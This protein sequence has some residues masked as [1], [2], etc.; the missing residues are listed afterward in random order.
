MSGHNV[1]RPIRRSVL[2]SFIFVEKHE[3][4]PLTLLTTAALLGI[5][6][7]PA[8]A[9]NLDEPFIPQS[10]IPLGPPI[11]VNTGGDWT[12]FYACG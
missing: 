12:G 2:M 5:A 9:G 7:S 3:K 4:M 10:P 6:I 8:L 1:G 11:M